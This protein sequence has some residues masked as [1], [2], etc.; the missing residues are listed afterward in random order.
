MLIV[1]GDGFRLQQRVELVDVAG[2][3]RAGDSVEMVGGFR[4]RRQRS[5]SDMASSTLGG[6]SAKNRNLLFGRLQPSDRLVPR[7]GIRQQL[8]V[9]THIGV[10]A[11]LVHRRAAERARPRARGATI[12]A[13]PAGYPARRAAASRRRLAFIAA[14]AWSR[15]GAPGP[16]RISTELRFGRRPPLPP[17][18]NFQPQCVA[19]FERRFDLVATA[20]A[21]SGFRRWTVPKR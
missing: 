11:G 8:I 19:G 18:G 9:D 3:P 10:V 16:C 15:A 21:V 2:K 1:L 20:I 4:L 13:R 7:L 12:P 5:G 6:K 17:L 14:S